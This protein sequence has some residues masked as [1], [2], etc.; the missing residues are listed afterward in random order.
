VAADEARVLREL[1][2]TLRDRLGSGIVVLGGK[3]DDKVL[4]VAVVTKD[5]IPRYQAGKIIKRLAR[6]LGGD[7][8]GR[9][10]MAQ[11]GGNRPELL[12]KVLEQV[13]D[14]LRPPEGA[15]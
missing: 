2:D 8:G 7:G 13:D 6:A 12:E 15:A 10:D 14:W 3:K 5:L 9:P 11:A 1:A 4:L